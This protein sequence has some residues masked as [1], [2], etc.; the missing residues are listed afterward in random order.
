MSMRRKRKI[1]VLALVV[2]AFVGFGAYIVSGLQPMSTAEA[3]KVFIRYENPTRLSTVLNDLKDR[4]I[5]RNPFAARVSSWFMRMD[6]T[7]SAGT[8]SVGPGQNSLAILWALRKPIKQILRLPETNWAN[9]TAH[10]LEGK[11]VTTADEYMALVRDPQQFA[12]DVSF[13]L[14]KD[15]LEGYLYPEHYD[16]PPLY[17]AK[18][19][20][21]KQLKE[22]EKNIWDSPDRPADFRRTLILASLVQLEAGKDSDRPMI[23]GVIE[24]R[25]KQKM[26]LQIDATICYALQK[27]R[28]LTFKDYRNVKSPYNTYLVKG[29]PPGPICSPDAKDIEAAMHPAKHNYLFY[30]ALPNGQSIY[31][32][33]YKEHLRNIKIRKEAMKAEKP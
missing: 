18:R 26:P 1:V 6:G 23:A 8:Y 22:F 27:W 3:Q 2:A 12:N 15:S 33:T 20:I 10:L 21:L 24:N 25:L 28:R 19:T 4:G 30:V 7:V 9:R 31:S 16:L 13:P 17:G 14:P 29:L 5:V 32:A 11:H